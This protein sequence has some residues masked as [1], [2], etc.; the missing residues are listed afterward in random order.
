M[1]T[2]LKRLANGLGK[3]LE[4]VPELYGDGLQ[5]TIKEGGKTL[6]LIP[7]TINAALVPLR[8]WIAEREHNFAVTEKLLAGKLENID[9]NK[10]VTPAPYVAIPALQA[11]SYS[12]NSEELR[13][14]YANLLAKAMNTDTKDYVHP[15]FSEIIKQM[16]PFDAT[17]LQY[18]VKEKPKASIKYEFY[19]EK[20]IYLY[21]KLAFIID[22]YPNLDD[23]EKV[24]ISFS[25]LSR[26]GILGISDD[27]MRFAVSGTRFEK[28][29]FY[30]KSE[31]ERA[32]QGVKGFSRLL[33]TPIAIT[34]FG[35]SFVK[36]C[37][38]D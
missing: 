32:A 34:P 20:E 11:I 13:D 19:D 9:S 33:G 7:Q 35:E 2:D 36:T 31:I 3:A 24:S 1:T 6:A 28:S 26:L 21:S 8:Q 14:L 17:F 4:V 30:K 10:I 16:S 27:A 15:S 29:E 37:L 38:F 25:S 12:M 23:V 18:F 5:P 22:E